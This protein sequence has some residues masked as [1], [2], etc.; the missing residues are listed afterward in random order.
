MTDAVWPRQER[1][2]S[3]WLLAT[4]LMIALTATACGHSA[5]L[6]DVAPPVVEGGGARVN[7]DRPFVDG[8]DI[9]SAQAGDGAAIQSAGQLSFTPIIPKFSVAPILV[10]V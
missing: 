9:S 5:Q 3:T 8:I 10:Q 4:T 7:W 1:A 6:K 2:K